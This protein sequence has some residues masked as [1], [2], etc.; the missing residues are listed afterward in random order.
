MKAPK[1]SAARPLNPEQQVRRLIARFKPKQQTLVRSVRSGLR[2]R[3]PTADELVYDY[4]KSLVIG[5]SPTERGSDA[6]VA[7]AAGADGVRLV[8]NQGPTLPDPNNILLGSGRATRFIWVDSP[9]TLKRPEVEA[10][11]NA[12][13]GAVKIPLRASG[14]GKVVVKGKGGK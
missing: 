3:F 6:V 13:A 2:K 8:F 1:K 9:G 7:L 14:S 12:A 4:T 10:M 11:M 5:Y